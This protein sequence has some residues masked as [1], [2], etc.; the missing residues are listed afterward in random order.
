MK[1]K[2]ESKNYTVTIKS[3]EKVSVPTVWKCSIR[4]LLQ[5]VYILQ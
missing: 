3:I 1:N 4:M 5:Y 2:I